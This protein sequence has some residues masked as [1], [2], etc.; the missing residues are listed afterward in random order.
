M[1]HLT[2]GFLVY[3]DVTQLDFTAP[4]QVFGC[5]PNV[6]IHLLWK[7]LNP[8]RAQDGLMILPTTSFVQCP[9]LDVLCV[10]GG[11]VGQAELLNDAEVIEFLHQT[12][13]TAKYITSVCTGSLLLA[14]AELLTGYRAACHWS[15]REHLAAFGVEVSTDRVVVDR[16]RITGGGVT[17]GLDFGLAIAAQLCGEETAK[18]IQLLLEYNPA[19]PFNC[20]SPET[21]DRKTR[22]IYDHLAKPI[23]EKFWEGVE[24]AIAS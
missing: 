7:N 1:T 14:A 3:P 16:N 17:A 20:G 4:H 22:A 5:L 18:T 13:Q 2:I 9:P 12:G 8:I 10:P 19:P 11:G 23:L 21:A 6:Q 15:F 24:G